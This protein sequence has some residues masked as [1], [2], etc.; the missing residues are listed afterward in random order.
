LSATDV[1]QN[2]PMSKAPAGDVE[3]IVMQSF[4][5]ADNSIIPIGEFA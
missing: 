2:H 4:F 3:D 5:H 1:T